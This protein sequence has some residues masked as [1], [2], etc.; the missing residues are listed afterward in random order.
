MSSRVNRHY[1][2]RKIKITCDMESDKNIY[3]APQCEVLE[4]RPEGVIAAS[5]P[6]PKFDPWEDFPWS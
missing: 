1:C 2:S 3:S 4:L 6:T 5:A